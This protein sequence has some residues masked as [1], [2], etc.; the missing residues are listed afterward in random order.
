[1]GAP[2]DLERR[3]HFGPLDVAVAVDVH[4]AMKNVGVF[5]FDVH[6]REPKDC[7]KLFP[8]HVAVVI[9]DALVRA[10]QLVKGHSPNRVLGTGPF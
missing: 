1:V 7:P 4:V 3:L 6:S 2:R 10:S 8:R 5:R 9:V